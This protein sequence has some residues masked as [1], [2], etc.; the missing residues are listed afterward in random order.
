MTY[1]YSF[2]AFII[3]GL[4]GTIYYKYTDMIE[5]IANQ[6]TIISN[7][8]KTI[9]SKDITIKNIEEAYNN[10]LEKVKAEVKIVENKK[11]IEKGTDYDKTNSRDITSTYIDLP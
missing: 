1:V 11:T 2:I 5:T 7:K 8:T 9:A 6:E 4:F 10:Q 3:I